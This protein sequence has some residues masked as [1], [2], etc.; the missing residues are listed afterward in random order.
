MGYIEEIRRQGRDAN[1][2]FTFMGIEI[3]SFGGGEAELAMEVTPRMYNGEG[4]MQGGIFSALSDEAMALA[5]YTLLSEE[6]TIAT[7]SETTSFLRGIREGTVI[8]RGKVIRKGKRIAFAEA[9]AL[10][11][12]EDGHILSRSTASF[13]VRSGPRVPQG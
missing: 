6:E 5:L 4:W 8:A 12:G 7:I 9:A 1:P 13:A 3:R 11:A 2:F 10:L